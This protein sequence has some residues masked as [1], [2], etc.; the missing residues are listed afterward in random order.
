MYAACDYKHWI[1][2]VFNP[3]MTEFDGQYYS[4]AT[5]KIRKVEGVEFLGSEIVLLGADRPVVSG[6]HHRQTLIPGFSQEKIQ[7]VKLGIIGLGGNGAQEAMML[8]SIGFRDFVLVEDDCVEESNLSRIPYASRADIGKFKVDIAARYIRMK[9]PEARIE[10]M[11]CKVEQAVEELKSCHVLI[12][13]VDNDGARKTLNELSVACLIPYLDLGC[14]ITLKDGELQ[15]FGQVRAIIPGETPC[16]ICTGSIDIQ[17]VIESRMSPDEK[18][19]RRAVGYLRGTDESPAPAIL[20]LNTGIASLATQALV[21]MVN[22]TALPSFLHL[23]MSGM[24]IKAYDFKPSKRCPVCGPGGL[25][26]EG[27]MYSANTMWK[28][29]PSLEVDRG[30]AR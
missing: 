30:E 9:S 3:G 12:G 13:C 1:D 21:C 22:G 24:K 27:V 2:L 11:A 7:G 18:E 8:A 29:I 16:L 17:E 6:E 28:E 15:Q 20:Q 25:F 5:K 26:A 4:P 10:P 14:E 23:D 19:S